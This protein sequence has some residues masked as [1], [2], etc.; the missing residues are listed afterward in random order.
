MVQQ[1][2]LF[3]SPCV[4]LHRCYVS[5]IWKL[6]LTWWA[7]CSSYLPK[8]VE[9]CIIQSCILG[10]AKVEP[11]CNFFHISNAA[12]HHALIDVVVM[13]CLLHSCRLCLSKLQMTLSLVAANSLLKEDW[14]ERLAVMVSLLSCWELFNCLDK[15]WIS[16]C[17]N[18]LRLHT[19]AVQLVLC[20]ADLLVIVECWL[21]WWS[22]I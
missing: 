8:R 15:A 19:V 9:C 18:Q 13:Y 5:Q 16:G 2:N 17:T 21:C 22:R 12:G 11:S 20:W 3:S 14:G 6:G 1:T 7:V 4:P 10:C